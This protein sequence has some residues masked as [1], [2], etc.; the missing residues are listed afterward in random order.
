MRASMMV[1]A[2]MAV[3]TQAAPVF[4]ASDGSW[5]AIREALFAGRELQDG[6]AVIAL[7]APKRAEDAAV[8]PVA[9][10]ALMAQTPER[11]IQTVHLIVDENPAPVAGVFHL[12]P[13]SGSAT[14]G[15]RIRVNQYTNLHAVAETSDGQLYV[16]ERFIKAAGGCSAPGMKDKAVAMARLGKMQ[17][18]PMS[19]FAP[20]QV[21]EAQLLISHPNYTGMQIDQVSRLW[22]PPDY[23]RT[24]KVSYGTTPVLEVEGDIAL[25]ED[26]AIS[27][28]FVPEGPGAMT[29]QVEDT[30]GR[31]FE[32]SWPVGPTS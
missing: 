17:L 28:S 11:W 22:I 7:E 12:H 20:G 31:K 23:V 3:L 32:Q 2:A 9:I 5:D 19:Q 25:S 14:I 15:T 8:V 1:V 26:P 4:A 10:K 18:K 24:V 6:S 16:V 21:N 29:V 27:F 13:Q 30:S